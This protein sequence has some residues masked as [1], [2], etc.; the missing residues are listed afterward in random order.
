[1]EEKA[2]V[3]PAESRCRKFEKTPNFYYKAVNRIVDAI[4][5]IDHNADKYYIFSY[6]LNYFANNYDDVEQKAFVQELKRLKKEKPQLYKEHHLDKVVEIAKHSDSAALDYMLYLIHIIKRPF[7]PL[8]TALET[9]LDITDPPRIQRGPRITNEND[10]EIIVIED[11]SDESTLGQGAVPEVLYAHVFNPSI[12]EMQIRRA[13]PLPPSTW[14]IIKNYAYSIEEKTHGVLSST[15]AGTAL[16]CSIEAARVPLL[17][18]IQATYPTS[19]ITQASFTTSISF[20]IGF[21]LAAALFG[22]RMLER[23]WELEKWQVFALTCLCSTGLSLG[24]AAFMTYALQIPTN[25]YAAVAIGAITGAIGAGIRMC[26]ATAETPRAHT[27]GGGEAKTNGDTEHHDAL[28][29]Y[30]KEDWDNMKHVEKA[31]HKL[32]RICANVDAGLNQYE[33]KQRDDLVLTTR[34][35]VAEH[36]EYLHSQEHI[37]EPRVKKGYWE[38]FTEKVGETLGSDRGYKTT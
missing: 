28:G 4:E 20:L 25:L 30:K 37:E 34:A 19:V 33:G 29:E 38:R 18:H 24:T 15:L 21:T 2:Y 3:R 22:S 7:K 1:M 31:Y 13:A 8:A 27:N 10:D 12:L 5:R 32:A 14:S 6:Y 26:S 11:I 36:I 23:R 17:Q 9:M 16:S 35:L